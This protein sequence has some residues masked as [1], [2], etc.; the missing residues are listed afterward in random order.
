MCSRFPRNGETADQNDREL[1]PSQTR[2]TQRHELPTAPNC[3]ELWSV[4]IKAIVPPIYVLLFDDMALIH[5]D[6][7]V[8]ARGSVTFSSMVLATG[9]VSLVALVVV[10]FVPVTSPTAPSFVR[11][12]HSGVTPPTILR[13]TAIP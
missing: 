5:T 12:N 13:R 7:R 8:C 10:L 11:Y 9:S 2:D 1:F 6:C 4:R 3:V